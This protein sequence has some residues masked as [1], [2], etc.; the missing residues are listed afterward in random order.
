[1]SPRSISRTTPRAI[2]RM[3]SSACCQ[4]AL[5]QGGEPVLQISARN[6]SR[7]NLQSEVIGAS[8]LG[9]RNILCVTG[10]SAKLSPSPHESM[11]INDLDAIQML[12]I[13]RRM[14][15][16]GKYLGGREIKASA[17]IFPGRGGFAVFIQ[18]KIPGIAGTEEGQ[19]R[20]AVFSD[21]SGVRHRW[22][23]NLVE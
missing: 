19:C 2:P 4:V 14:R 11:E 7:S 9:V 8:A 3:S 22:H 23:G 18:S 6:R 10:D 12:W 1:M 13:L 16:E 17:P 20:R 21:Q 15:D 5:K